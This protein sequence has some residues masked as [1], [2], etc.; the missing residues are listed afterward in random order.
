MASEKIL[1]PYN[2]TGYDQRALDFVIR[3]F[4]HLKDVEVTLFHTI[5]LC[6]R[7]TCVRPDAVRVVV[8]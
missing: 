1:L 7:L 2:F 5:H 3:T 8:R 6:R 4:S